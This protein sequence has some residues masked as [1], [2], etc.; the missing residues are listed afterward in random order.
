MYPTSFNV[1]VNNALGLEKL[2][3]GALDGREGG[4]TRGS[5]HPLGLVPGLR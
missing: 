4:G 2:V 3:I 5:N 1:D